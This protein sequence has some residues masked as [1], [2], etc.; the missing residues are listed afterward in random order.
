[1]S[2]EPLYHEPA[3]WMQLYRHDITSKVID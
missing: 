2:S 1:V 3:S